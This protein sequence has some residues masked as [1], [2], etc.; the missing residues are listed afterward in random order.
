VEGSMKKLL[1]LAVMV[2]LGVV[3]ARVLGG[4]KA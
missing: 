3:A 4:R 2:A 1:I